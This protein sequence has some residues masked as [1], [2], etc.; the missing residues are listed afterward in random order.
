M[1]ASV[2]RGKWQDVLP[3]LGAGDVVVTDPPYGTGGRR[4]Q[5]A[6]MGGEVR[7]AQLVREEWDDGSVEWLEP[8]SRASAVLTFWPDGSLLSMLLKAKECGLE[9]VRPVYLHKPDPM[10]QPCGRTRFSVEPVWCLSRPG[11]VLMG[12][13]DM[14]TA[15]TP[16]ANRDLGA[17][18]HPYEKPLAFMRWLIAKIPADLRVVDPFCG[19]GTTLAAAALEGREALGC[20]FDSKWADYAERRAQ[21]ACRAYACLPSDSAG[22]RQSALFGAP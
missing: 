10:P 17:S 22:G 9:K 8:A 19:S 6:G 18:G 21:E 7:G 2:L 11:F 12:G 13:D 20:E 15:S 5:K 3:E 1:N 4:R 14:F 16:R